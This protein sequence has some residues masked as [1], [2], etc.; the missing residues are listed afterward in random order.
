MDPYIRFRFHDSLV[1]SRLREATTELPSSN[2][3]N[4]AILGNEMQPGSCYT[5]TETRDHSQTDVGVAGKASL[6]GS[7][8][9]VAAASGV[10]G[11]T[12]SRGI[13]E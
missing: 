4:N 11:A 3:A 8:L 6:G 12:N 1:G 10:D 7:I 13:V 5:H 2:G 9:V